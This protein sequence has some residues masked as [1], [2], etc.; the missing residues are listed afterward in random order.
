M[1]QMMNL[2]NPPLD[3]GAM[4][5]A[6]MRHLMGNVISEAMSLQSYVGMQS[7][8]I[9]SS[10]SQPVPPIVP[11]VK[12]RRQF[13]KYRKDSPCA[14]VP[15]RGPD[16]Q[17]LDQEVVQAQLAS[18]GLHRR[19]CRP[20]DVPRICTHVYKYDTTEPV[21]G[22]KP[23][24]FLQCANCLTQW[25]QN[26][27]QGGWRVAMHKGPCGKGLCVRSPDADRVLDEVNNSRG[28]LCSR[29]H[30]LC[31]EISSS[32]A[33]KSTCTLSLP[34]S[35]QPCIPSMHPVTRRC[36]PVTSR[37]ILCRCVRF[38]LCLL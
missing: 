34:E 5:E 36:T 31:N 17:P 23:E 26:T 32:E 13:H 20:S 2:H 18:E 27:S 37:C 10:N 30:V 1:T 6:T 4:Q 21:A 35:M 3:Q 9:Q 29:H 24:S 28:K 16:R 7:N 25:K 19:V 12:L 15:S 14:L 33:L 11:V 22:A 8:G 38:P